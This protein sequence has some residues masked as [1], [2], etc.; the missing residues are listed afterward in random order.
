MKSVTK[1]NLSGIRNRDSLRTRLLLYFMALSLVP[2]AIIG[3]ISYF[4]SQNAL[5]DRIKLDLKAQTNLQGTMISTFL[6]E[7]KDNMLVLAGTA[8]VRTMDPAKAVDAIDQYYKQ[9]VLYENLGLYDLSG[10]TVY[11]TDKTKISVGDRLYFQDAL[12][13]KTTFSDPVVSKATG[14]IV[15]VVASPVIEGGKTLGVITG[16]I[17]TTVF[18]DYI[19][20]SELGDGDGFLIKNDGALITPSNHSENLQKLGTIKERSELELKPDTV[21]VTSILAGKSGVEEYKDILGQPVIGSF[22]PIKGSTWGLVIEHSTS[23]VLE[24]VYRLRN[25]FF[26]VII[27][28]IILVLILAILVSNNITRPILQMAT[29]SQ[30][31]ARGEIPEEEINIRGKDEIALLAKSFQEIIQYFREISKQFS[32]LA[33]GD[34]TI[35]V[36]A[37]SDSDLLG[38]SFGRMVQR[39]REIIRQMAQHA[40]TLDQASN[41]LAETAR[42]VDSVTTQIATTIQQVAKGTTQQ[43]DSITRTAS[44]VED[45]SSAV[46][47]VA[48]G[49]QDQA[50]AIIRASDVTSQLTNAIQHV[51][52]NAQSVVDGSATA[53]DAAKK[54]S[55]IVKSTLDEMQ[56]IKTSVGLSSQKVQEMGDRS[57]QIGD[58]LTTIEDIASQT[59]MLALNAAIEA[60]RAG[61]TGKGFAVVADEVRKLAERVSISTQEIDGL[62]KGIQ[63]IVVEANKAMIQGTIEVDKGVELAHQAGLALEE[64]LSAAESVNSQ[65][66]EAATAAGTMTTYA[67][68]LVTE[69]DTVSDV[70]ERNTAATEQ[71]SASTTEVTQ[72]VENI[73]SV[74]EENSAA[75]E[76]VSASTEEMA[77]RVEEVSMAAHRLSELSQQLKQMVNQFRTD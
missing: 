34:L 33:D 36:K 25:I 44:N 15:F 73:A 74:S 3:L 40:T 42:D 45:L 49:A 28:A 70:V 39:L 16:S 54:G 35:S 10:E 59:N 29:M 46:G 48:R 53:K 12:A 30:R 56:S 32:Q 22:M 43:T 20:S 72:A 17:P 19:N 8:R 41:E 69:V 13:G 14:N 66:E 2:L 51:S 76:E 67:T 9:W 63:T 37:H 47:S 50:N 4:Q 71:M 77:A 23:E 52:G 68:E 7:R 61:D 64:I 62:I 60:A 75:A 58:I 6:S 18:K 55:L 1:Q 65:A 5:T 26:L 24:A 21:A 27:V 38:L 57:G 31:I 11:R